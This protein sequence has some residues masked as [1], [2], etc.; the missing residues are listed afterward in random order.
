[1]LWGPV[2]AWR[3]GRAW[4]RAHP[5]LADGLGIAPVF[6]IN[7]V[8]AV[9]SLRYPAFVYVAVAFALCAPIVVRR[10]WPRAAFA[11]V[12]LVAFAQ[13]ALGITLMP[14]DLALFVAQY[15][16][17]TRCE[18]PYAAVAACTMGIGAVLAV[19]RWTPV[20]WP[21]NL[22]PSAIFIGAVWVLGHSVRTRRAYLA[23]LVERAV[24]A[25]RERDAN[26]QVAAAE[27]RA[28]IARELH[29]VI[30]H[31]MSVMVV[32]SDG[33]AYAIDGDPARAKEALRTISSTGRQAL[34]EMRRML[35]V[36]R[37]GEGEGDTYAPQ[38]GV[39]QLRELIDQVRR[40]GIV[41]D[42][43]VEG[44]PKSVPKG[45]ELA[46]YRVVQ[47]ALTNTLKHA[48]PQA[49]AAVRLRYGD[50]TLDVSVVDDGRGAA[51]P[52]PDGQGHGLN[53]MRERVEMYGGAV[54]A[55]PRPGGGYE[56]AA[57]M[58]LEESDRTVMS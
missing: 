40:S 46:A 56:V 38:P 53:G 33:A 57:R 27:E 4:L 52:A 8:F 6:L 18:R 20:F 44:A 31:S 3:G 48:G 11:A 34:T 45:L 29:D 55:G 32:Q 43:A 12:A 2:R 54:R 36:L 9:S 42:L 51:A 13:W 25:E 39:A 35:G 19:G 47:E 14:A 21:Q 7:T 15:T 58:P 41:V 37:A 22:I 17:A 5:R 10:Q 26:A 30:A 16:V 24:R 28:R 1:M 23:G 50:D 49:S